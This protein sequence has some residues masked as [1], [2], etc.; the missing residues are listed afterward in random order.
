[1]LNETITLKVEDWFTKGHDMRFE[2]G[3]HSRHVCHKIKSYMW[4]PPSEAVDWALE[5][6]RLA[7]FKRKGL[8]HVIVIPRL[9]YSLH[10]LMLHKESD[11]VLCL[12]TDFRFWPAKM[13]SPLILELVLPFSRH[14]PWTT[15]YAPKICAV[16]RKLQ[17]IW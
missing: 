11:L 1:M 4:T 14:Q 9:F 17:K 13:H 5:Q 2:K 6:L 10:R 15:K 16:G 3:S 7:R 12:P 8:I